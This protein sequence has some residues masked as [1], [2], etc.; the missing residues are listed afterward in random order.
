MNETRQAEVA[1][2]CPECGQWGA[3]EFGSHLLPDYESFVRYR[4]C[5][6]TPVRVVVG[7]LLH[8]VR[9]RTAAEGQERLEAALGAVAGACPHHGAEC[10]NLEG[11]MASLDPN[12]LEA[13]TQ[14]AVEDGMRTEPDPGVPEWLVLAIA[15]LVGY[16]ALAW[17]VF[18][19]VT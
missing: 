7:P 9:V 8:F 3:T 13:Q 15:V 19:T 5:E 1:W 17:A 11:L 2:I 18:V 12:E 14:V 10:P 6:V 16:A 4:K